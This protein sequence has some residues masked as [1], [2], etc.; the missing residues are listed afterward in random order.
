MEILG[1]AFVK[2]NPK[3]SHSPIAR[4]YSL[5]N[6][7]TGKYFYKFSSNRK[8]GSN[9]DCENTIMLCTLIRL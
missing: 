2:K 7:N 8:T 3:K 9:S 4:K 5:Q 1:N 6:L